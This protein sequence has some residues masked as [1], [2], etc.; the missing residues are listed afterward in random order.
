MHIKLILKQKD[1][2]SQYYS[3]NGCWK[4]KTQHSLLIENP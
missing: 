3:I 1:G 4:S 2:I